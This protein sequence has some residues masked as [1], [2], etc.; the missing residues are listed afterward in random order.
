[1]N[2]ISNQLEK[3]VDEGCNLPG[4]ILAEIIYEPKKFWKRI[5]GT[6]FKKEP[7]WK[8]KRKQV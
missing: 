7:L 1:M 6:I 5:C 3:E 4:Y 8:A 2:K